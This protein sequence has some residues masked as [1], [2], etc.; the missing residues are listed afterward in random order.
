MTTSK[1]PT[2]H[3]EA[4]AM[5]RYA[6]IAALLHVDFEHGERSATLRNLSRR[7]YRPPGSHRTRRYGYSTIERWHYAYLNDG[8]AAL[9]PGTRKDKGR[10]RALSPE[11]QKLL[12]DIVPHGFV[13]IGPP[14]AQQRADH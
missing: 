13:T 3:A 5:F 4:V 7:L 12:I 9:Y 10:A 2:D 6:I 8:I 14:Y 11:L 1:V